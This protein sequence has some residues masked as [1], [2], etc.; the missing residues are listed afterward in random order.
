MNNSGITD[1]N[2]SCCSDS[3]YSYVDLYAVVEGRAP[4]ISKQGNGYKSDTNVS[5]REEEIFE[6]TSPEDPQ[7]REQ[8][9]EDDNN[10]SLS[11]AST[12]PIFSNN[13]R[14]SVRQIVPVDLV[15]AETDNQEY[16]AS[17]QRAVRRNSG[18]FRR[19]SNENL[20]HSPREERSLIVSSQSPSDRGDERRFVL[21]PSQPDTGNA[22]VSQQQQSTNQQNQ[23]ESDHDD[24]TSLVSRSSRYSRASCPSVIQRPIRGINPVDSDDDF[25]IYNRASTVQ[26]RVTC[27][28]EVTALVPNSSRNSGTL[29]HRLRQQRTTRRPL[30]LPGSNQH[31][32]ELDQDNMSLVSRN[33]RASC[34]SIIQRPNRGVTPIE[35]DDAS[36]YS[37]ASTVQSRAT[38]PG[39][40]S[41]LGR[42]SSHSTDTVKKGNLSHFHIRHSSRSKNRSASRIQNN[43]AQEGETQNIELGVQERTDA[44]RLSAQQ[45]QEESNYVGS[46][47]KPDEPTPKEANMNADRIKEVKTTQEENNQDVIVKTKDKIKEKRRI[48]KLK[49]ESSLRVRSQSPKRR[50]KSKSSKSRPRHQSQQRAK[51]R[52]RSISRPRYDETNKIASK[53]LRR[54]SNEKVRSRAESR[55]RQRCKSRDKAQDKNSLSNNLEKRSR[56]KS[57]SKKKK[58]K[59]TEKK[60]RSQSVPPPSRKLERPPLSASGTGDKKVFDKKGRFSK[61]YMNQLFT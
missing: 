59:V 60:K 21:L 44:A 3:D 40:V 41:N 12:L 14:R 47:E 42:S 57:K 43:I 28:G 1:D 30:R 16:R 32:D 9:P 31:Q 48:Q 18:S 51:P 29:N 38:C 8:R 5:V 54:F 25:S 49:K 22:V 20:S 34:P 2:K 27:P 52:G 23:E 10:G 6:K 15:G 39:N 24:N 58:K 17:Y 61:K 33:S 13:T 55:G 19:T 50:S 36:V 56:C 37:R 11:S 53:M 4:P 46:S 26:S 45:Q 35:G 7:E